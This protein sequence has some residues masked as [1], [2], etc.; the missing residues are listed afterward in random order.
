[1]KKGADEVMIQQS[2]F[3][4]RDLKKFKNYEQAYHQLIADIITQQLYSTNLVLKGT[5][6]K[7]IFV[8]GGFGKN[9][10]FMHMM[11][12][13]FTGIEVY[14]A[15]VAQASALGAALVMHEHWNKKVL[16]TDIIELKYYSEQQKR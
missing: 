15:S 6:V 8:D 12:D 10:I 1:M 14:A 3:A 7:R 16:P 13:V 9:P 2:V 11:A 4:K 5:P